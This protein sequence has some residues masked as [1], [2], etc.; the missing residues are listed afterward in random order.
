[1]FEPL[2]E[3][4]GA[5]GYALDT[6]GA[7]LRGL[8]AGD[9]GQRRSGREM[10]EK[11]GIIDP[12]QAGFDPGDVAGFGA[13]VLLDPFTWLGGG[14]LKGASVLSKGA[15][16]A[17]AASGIEAGLATNEALAQALLGAKIPTGGFR[18]ATQVVESGAGT[19]TKLMESL[20]KHFSSGSSPISEMY[21]GTFAP[22]S[23]GIIGKYP[24][25]PF[26]ETG[27]FIRGFYSPMEPATRT[28]GKFYK[29]PTYFSLI[30]GAEEYTGLEETLRA[31]DNIK[32]GQG[33]AGWFGK[34]RID[35]MQLA[36]RKEDLAADVLSTDVARY[37]EQLPKNV[38]KFW[39]YMVRFVPDENL[40]EATRRTTTLARQHYLDSLYA[41]KTGMYPKGSVLGTYIKPEHMQ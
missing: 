3:A 7:Y 27:S 33:A 26:T 6:P 14:L 37:W 10:L 23:P 9:L 12:N 31:I 40:F 11:W 39:E 8:L 4:L 18:T 25:V 32:G 41:T 15:K 5:V 24:R 29:P 36:N 20:A 16:S 1:M 30:H 34:Y 35:F 2:L 22:L 17:K 21:A 38:Q 13:E 28:T 19:K